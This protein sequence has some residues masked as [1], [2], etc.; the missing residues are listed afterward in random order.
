MVIFCTRVGRDL[1]GASVKATDLRAGAALVIAGLM[2]EGKTE[3]T[4]IEFILRGY[5]DIIEKLR[6]LGADIRLVED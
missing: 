4:N 1:R 5:S 2:A 6:N 3:I